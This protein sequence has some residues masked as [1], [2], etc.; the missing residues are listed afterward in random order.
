MTKQQ[1]YSVAEAAEL[2]GYSEET[3]RRHIRADKLKAAGGGAGRSPYRIAR[4]ELA[5]W[6]RDIGGGELLENDT[7]VPLRFRVTSETSEGSL[8]PHN[9]GQDGFEEAVEAARQAVYAGQGPVRVEIF[10]MER[11]HQWERPAFEIAFYEGGGPLA[12]RM[13][14]SEHQDDWVDEESREDIRREIELDSLL[15]ECGLERS[16]L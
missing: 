3:I 7:D 1:T 11:Q 15:S 5:R 14:W 4:T 10:R 13:N 2:T 12:Y 6:W 16:A 9:G 8:S